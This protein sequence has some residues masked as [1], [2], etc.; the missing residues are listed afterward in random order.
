MSTQIAPRTVIET[1]VPLRGETGLRSVYDAANAVGIADQPLRLAIR[2]MITAGELEQH[3]R[4]RTG[5]LT[6][7]R[8][9]RIRLD[10]DQ[11][12]LNLAA[13]QDDGE[14]R[15]DGAWRLIAISAP[16]R[17]RALRDG[18]RRDLLAAGAAKISTGLYLSPHDLTGLLDESAR[19]HLVTAEARSLDLRGLDDPRDI[20]EQLWPA[21]AI[22]R[23]YDDV[24][25]AVEAD[26]LTWPVAVRRIRL[27]DALERAMRDDPLLPPELRAKPWPPTRHRLAWRARWSQTH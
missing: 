2:R 24:A 21:A 27:A 25:R 1:L 20:G 4:G 18:L 11:L 19:A 12:A 15:W 9:G 8:S 22:I 17:L 14:V 13:A 3:G 6:L 7:T 26:D 23:R 5:S 16:E 10:R